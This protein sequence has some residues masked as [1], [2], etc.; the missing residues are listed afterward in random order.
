M[1]RYV[2]NHAMQIR[3]G[4]RNERIEERKDKMNELKY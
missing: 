4:N 3:E 1:N 2:E